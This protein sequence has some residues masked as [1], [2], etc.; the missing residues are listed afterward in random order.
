MHAD[1]EQPDAPCLYGRGQLRAY[2]G[3][4]QVQAGFRLLTQKQREL[5]EFEI[6]GKLLSSL[7]NIKAYQRKEKM[8]IYTVLYQHLKDFGGC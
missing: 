7:A 3:Y 2:L 5:Q 8:D 4:L 6:Y 1:H